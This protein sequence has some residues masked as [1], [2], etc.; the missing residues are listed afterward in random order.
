M[1]QSW[2]RATALHASSRNSGKWAPGKSPR[3]NF[4]PSSKFA[5]RCAAEASAR[6]GRA[7][8][9][10]ETTPAVAAVPMKSRLVKFAD[11]ERLLFEAQPHRLDGHVGRAATAMHNEFQTLDV[12]D[13]DAAVRIAMSR[14]IA[15]IVPQAGEGAWSE[16]ATARMEVFQRNGNIRPHTFGSCVAVPSHPVLLDQGHV[17]GLRRAVALQRDMQRAGGIGFARGHGIPHIERSGI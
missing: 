4:Q 11:M 10:P 5:F 14:Q 6:A 1:L 15:P 8:P 2:G 9:A 12:L 13:R 16:N 7:K 17:E 3:E